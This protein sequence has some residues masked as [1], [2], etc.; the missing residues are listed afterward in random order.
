MNESLMGNF[1]RET[2]TVLLLLFWIER[3][4]CRWDVLIQ[5]S[6][7]LNGSTMQT[8]GNEQCNLEGQIRQMQKPRTKFS[9]TLQSSFLG[10]PISLHVLVCFAFR[11]IKT[12]FFLWGFTGDKNWGILLVIQ[13]PSRATRRLWSGEFPCSTQESCGLLC[14]D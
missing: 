3:N 4:P 10:L 7:N 2:T 6:Y 11:F 9:C 8:H 12:V 13:R 5:E 14:D 1:D